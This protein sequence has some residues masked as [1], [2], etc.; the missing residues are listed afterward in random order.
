MIRRALLLLTVAAVYILVKRSVEAPA[1]R[2]PDQQANA[3]WANEGG[4]NAAPNV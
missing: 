3:D 2:A 1:T 4:A